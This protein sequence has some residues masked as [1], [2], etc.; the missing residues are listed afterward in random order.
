MAETK[1]IKAA[2]CSCGAERFVPGASVYIKEPGVLTTNEHEKLAQCNYVVG[3]IDDHGRL[4]LN[5]TAEE[6]LAG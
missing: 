6:A 2:F 5:K 1:E 3:H 4:K